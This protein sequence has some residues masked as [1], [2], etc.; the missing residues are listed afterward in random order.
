MKTLDPSQLSARAFYAYLNSAVAP[1]PIAFASTV[2]AA[3][4][5]NLSPFSFFNVMGIDPP[6]LVFAPNRRGRDNTAKHTSLNLLEVPELVINMVSYAMVEQMSL[7]SAEFERGVDEFVK[8]GFTAVA[9]ERVRPPRVGESPAQF[10]CQV[11]EIKTI[12]SMELVIAEVILA[13]F[14]EEILD[15]NGRIDQHRTD[16]VARL[17]GDWYAR[18]SGA[19][20]FEVPRPQMGVG[21]DALPEAVRTSRILT[22]NDLGRLGS[23]LEVPTRAE[24]ERFRQTP[25]MMALH[26]EARLGCQY[27]PDLLH[28]HA[29]KLLARGQVHE[30]WL[31]LLQSTL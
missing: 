9:S 30:A 25:A 11:L 26:E 28:L 20:L 19:A 4:R 14:S 10:E 27:L 6:I 21:V 18:A 12:G 24:I 31:T 8:A 17:G 23:V 15:E 16:W 29:Q 7:T 3:G 5:V 22:G 1:R 2:D 13:H